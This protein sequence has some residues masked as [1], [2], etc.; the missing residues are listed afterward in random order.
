MNQI[1]L[2]TLKSDHPCSYL[3]KQDANSVFLS[4]EEEVDTD[5]YNGLNTQGFRR[6]GSHYYRPHCPE[7]QACMASRLLVSQFNWKR[8][9]KRLLNKNNHLDIDLQI[10]S[11]TPETYDL[12]KRYINQ[13]HSDGDMYPASEKQFEDFLINGRPE[14][15]FLCAYDKN[16]LIAVS[17]IDLMLDGISAIYSF[18]DPDYAK[19]GLG[20]WLILQNILSAQEAQIPYLYLGYYIRESQKMSYKADFQPLEVYSDAKWKPLDWV[21]DLAK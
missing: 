21:H 17:V 10:P 11:N 2:Y 12:F 16:K 19:Q 4:P 3:K 6:S 13:R 15:R 1:K 14:T 5:T 9:F 18:F 7:C 20:T 8:R